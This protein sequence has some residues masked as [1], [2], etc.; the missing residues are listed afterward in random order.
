[1]KKNK[2]LV[3]LV[4]LVLVLLVS[5]PSA[6]AY[7][8]TYTITKGTKTIHIEDST[9]IN[10][11]VEDW[12]KK[13]VLKA[14]SGSDY[15]FVRVKIFAPDYI[16]DV[17]TI[18]GKDWKKDG[19]Y[20]YFK[21]AINNGNETEQLNVMIDS[22]KLPNDSK[23]GDEFH[24]I[25]VYESVPASYDSNNQMYADWENSKITVLTEGGNS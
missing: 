10:E 8:S 24:I 2:M 1:M 17:L 18:S 5:V 9:Q 13:I 6:L 16:S 11:I 12:T 23:E 25:V 15:V 22:T 19:D 21:K 14:D 7:F 20:F 3:V 4:S